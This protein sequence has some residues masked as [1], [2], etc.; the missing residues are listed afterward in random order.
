MVERFVI[1]R[2]ECWTN[3]SL[4]CTKNDSAASILSSQN[5][6]HDCITRSHFVGN[7]HDILPGHLTHPVDLKTLPGHFTKWP[8]RN[9]LTMKPLPPQP[10]E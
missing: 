10:A 2:F 7:E 8:L 4:I 9:P 6:S 3:V 1:I 5:G